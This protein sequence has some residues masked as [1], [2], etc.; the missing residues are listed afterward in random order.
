[1]AQATV[2]SDALP[3]E[4]TALDLQYVAHQSLKLDLWIVLLTVRQL[5][6]RGSY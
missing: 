1:L 2:R 6:A 5:L 4:R 3:G